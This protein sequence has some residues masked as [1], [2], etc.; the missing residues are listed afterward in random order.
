MISFE[1]IIIMEI[2]IVLG[3]MLFHLPAIAISA[4]V[5]GGLCDLYR[6]DHTSYLPI[7]DQKKE[8]LE[9]SGPE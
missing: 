8:F 6:L 1:T 3:S 2:I 4:I 7:L 5:I 9:N